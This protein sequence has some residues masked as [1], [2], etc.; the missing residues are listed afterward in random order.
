MGRIA[1][2]LRT[3]ASQ[4]AH[5]TMRSSQGIEILMRPIPVV[6]DVK[7]RQTNDEQRHVKYEHAASDVAVTV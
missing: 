5:W 1:D 7:T 2:R 4:S 6:M 3:L